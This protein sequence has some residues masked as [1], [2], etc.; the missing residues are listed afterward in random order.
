M[1]RLFLS[2]IGYCQ[3]LTG[4]L[5][6]Y[7]KFWKRFFGHDKVLSD[8][9]STIA[10]SKA[11][12]AAIIEVDNGSFGVDQLATLGKSTGLSHKFS[13]VKYQPQ[14]LGMLFRQIPV[15]K[16][17]GNGVLSKFPLTQTESKFFSSGAKRLFIQTVIHTP[18]PVTM[19]VV[20]LAL[21]EA[22]RKVQFKEL[23]A[24]VR[25]LKT[26]YIIVGDFNAHGSEI[27]AFCHAAGVVNTHS[28]LASPYTFPRY[29]PSKQIDYIL[30]S[31][32]IS[33]SCPQVISESHS[34]HLALCVDITVSR[35]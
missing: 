20:H 11:D 23:L 22:T 31:K 9:S 3:N 13:D 21:D 29:Q 25:T 8:I 28:S 30:V 12:V 2:N 33:I 18:D 32:E 17:Q 5:F 24:A 6:G 27:D 7:T 26:P 10:K 34:D 14:G 15:L 1:V 19:L 4:S 35:P 16:N